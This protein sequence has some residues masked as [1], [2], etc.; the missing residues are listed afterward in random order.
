MHL[1]LFTSMAWKFICTVCSTVIKISRKLLQ[2][3]IWSADR[4]WLVD[5][6]VKRMVTS[7]LS[8][9]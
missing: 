2:P 6:L 5:Y 1:Y 7:S 8:A 4:G 3:Q 9:R